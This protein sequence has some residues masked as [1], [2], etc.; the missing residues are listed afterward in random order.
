MAPADGSDLVTWLAGMVSDASLAV[1]TLSPRLPR[2]LAAA[3][4]SLPDSLGIWTW[5]LPD[6]TTRLTVEP[7]AA[8]AAAAGVWLMTWFSRTVSEFCWVTDDCS[9]AWLRMFW[10]S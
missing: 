9:P 4:G 3:V 2:S 1:L 6:D 7:L 8:W 10:A 5:A